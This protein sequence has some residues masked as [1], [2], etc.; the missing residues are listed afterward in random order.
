LAL[1]IRGVRDHCE[2]RHHLLTQLRHGF[3]Q[4]ACLGGSVATRRA[5]SLVGCSFDKPRRQLLLERA[6]H[7][8]FEIALTGRHFRVRVRDSRLQLFADEKKKKRARCAPRDGN[9][10]DMGKEEKSR[11]ASA[12]A[13]AATADHTSR[14]DRRPRS[15]DSVLFSATSKRRRRWRQSR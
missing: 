12:A 1:A 3:S 2:R 15:R 5:A 6:I 11:T 8:A 4:L 14:G 7:R 10:E 9:E 13:A